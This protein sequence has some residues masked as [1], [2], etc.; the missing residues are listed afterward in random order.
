MVFCNYI[1]LKKDRSLQYRKN[2]FFAGK[3][4]LKTFHNPKLDVSNIVSEYRLSQ[5][6]EN[7]KWLV[8]IVKI[9]I[10]LR[11]QYIP[12][13]GHRDDG[14]IVTNETS[15]HNEG[16]FRAMLRIQVDSGGKELGSHLNTATST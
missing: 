13:R 15:L 6:E 16:N 7:R 8:P 3:E 9:I 4:C 10:L 2:K 11:R 14:K 12:L 5:S 1:A